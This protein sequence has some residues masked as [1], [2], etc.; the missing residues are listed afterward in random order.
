MNK[1]LLINFRAI[2]IL[3]KIIMTFQDLP[4]CQSELEFFH[5]YSGIVFESQKNFNEIIGDRAWAADLAQGI[6]SFGNDLVFEIQ[7]LGT[8]SHENQTWFWSWANQDPFITDA[9]RQ[10]AVSL[11]EYGEEHNLQFLSNAGFDA[12][13]RVVNLLGVIASIIADTSCY[14]YGRYNNVTMLFNIKGG[15]I[16]HEDQDKV[17][18]I[19]DVYQDVL[20]AISEEDY[21]HLDI[22]RCYLLAKGF[23]VKEVEKEYGRDL[24]GQRNGGMLVGKF[25]EN[26]HL[27]TLTAEGF[28]L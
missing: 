16:E 20:G 22:L 24:I 4:P 1:H 9:I 5:R 17:Q 6:I 3:K 15:V 19:L 2:L 25:D 12:Q 21:D 18:R 11:K 27:I 23:K 7:L 26:S 28:V 10:D 8:F 13:E 14:Y